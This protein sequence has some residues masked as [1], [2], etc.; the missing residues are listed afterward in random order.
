[1]KKPRATGTGLA[2]ALVYGLAVLFAALACALPFLLQWYL[3]TYGVHTDNRY[4][5]LLTAYYASLPEAAVA[6]WHLRRLLYSVRRGDVFTGKSVTSLQVLSLCCAAVA[7]IT[8]VT[9]LLYYPLLIIAL[10][11]AFMAVILRVLRQVFAAAVVLK[12]ENE[13]T[14]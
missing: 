11:A 7:L 12:T 13:L 2:L 1:M 10:A 5:V 6:L 14:I 9:G 8:L 4:A 3:E